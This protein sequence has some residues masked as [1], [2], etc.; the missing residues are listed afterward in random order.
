LTTNSNPNF[1]LLADAFSSTIGVYS[2]TLGE[3]GSLG[4]GKSA[5]VVRVDGATRFEPCNP[6]TLRIPGEADRPD[7]FAPGRGWIPQAPVNP[8]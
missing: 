4:K 2:R 8:L 7:I 1:P 3:K 6:K 5:L